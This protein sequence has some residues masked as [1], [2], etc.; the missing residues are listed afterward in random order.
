MSYVENYSVTSLN[1][2]HPATFTCVLY[3]FTQAN[4]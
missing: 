4:K 1:G 3:A 2:M